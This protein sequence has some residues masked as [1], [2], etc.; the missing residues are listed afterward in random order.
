[1]LWENLREFFELHEPNEEQY[2]R[3]KKISL[4]IEGIFSLLKP[5]HGEGEWYEWS[6]MEYEEL[7]SRGFNHF[8]TGRIDELP[9]RLDFVIPQ[10]NRDDIFIDD[11]EYKPKK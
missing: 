11:G 7:K 8:Y 10:I 9:E 1:M 5:I 3:I 4:I 6:A 2:H